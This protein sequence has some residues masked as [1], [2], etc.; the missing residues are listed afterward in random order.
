M[1]IVILGAG[2]TG[3]GAAWRLEQAGHDDWE[4]WEATGE[5][6]GLARSITDE[7]GFTW[8]IGGHVQFSHY[9]TF[10]EV[11]DAALGEGGWLHHQRESWV[12]ICNTWVPYP[13]Q[14]NLH[15]LPQDK[16][17]K[18]IEGLVEVCRNP[19]DG[20]FENFGE[21]I[22]GTCGPGLAELFMRPYNFKVWAWPPE[23][24]AAGWIGDRVALPDLNKIVRS[25]VTKQDNVSWGPNNTFRFP[26]HGGTG[27][28]WKAVAG[29]MPGDR[30][31]FS[32]AVSRIDTNART[33]T[34]EDGTQVVY[35]RLISSLPLDRL[36][37]IAH[38]DHLR[39]SAELLQYSTVHI[40]GVGLKGS[41]G[42]ELEGKCWMYFPE[43]NCPFYR[44][45]VFSHY[46]PHNVPD[47]T[48]YWSLMAEVSQ[49]PAKPV[50]PS[51]IVDETIEGMLQTGLFE[52]R[53]QVHHTWHHELTRGYPTPGLRRDEA[54]EKILPELESLG[55]FSRG[56]FG[57][58]KY[59]V[60]NQD[61]SFSQGVEAV[62]RVLYNTPELT[63]WFPNQVNSLH[64]VFGKDW[65]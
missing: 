34:A 27:S 30:M 54:L 43:P 57:A 47:I 45:T 50:D 46:S 39:A 25:V 36:V 21:L 7:H 29:W 3:L 16:L 17:L 19:V 56:R 62:N 9:R 10:D 4:L 24:L 31:N 52:N 53:N 48:R 59:E 60:S 26:K 1:K 37:D 38:L 15:R 20:R 61:H 23:K 49:S 55:I 42:P 63:L 11:M 51:T 64:P 14:Y 58:W 12:R 5:P 28:V 40:I 35:D 6:G 8:D 44:V 2:P 41:C 65:L 32:R 18:C 33:L 22:D 13:F